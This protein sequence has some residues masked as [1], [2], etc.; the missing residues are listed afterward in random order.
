MPSPQGPL[1]THPPPTLH[2]SPDDPDPRLT[3]LATALFT[4]LASHGAFAQD[5]KLTI[6]MSGWPASPR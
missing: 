4:A 3:L 6:A 2:R 1:A 5:T